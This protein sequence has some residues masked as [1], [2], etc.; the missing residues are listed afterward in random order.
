MLSGIIN[1]AESN[2]PEWL[3]ET[4]VPESSD[5]SEKRDLPVWKSQCKRYILW[6][7]G[8]GSWHVCVGDTI[9][10]GGP[11]LNHAESDISLLANISRRHATLQRHGEDWFIHANHPTVVSGRTVHEQTFLRTGDEIRLGDRVRLGFRIPSP[12]ATTAVV[13]FESDHRPAQSVNGIILMTDNCLLGPRR[14]YHIFCPDWP[15]LLVLFNRDDRLCC[16]SNIP[17]KLNQTPVRD[18]AELEHGSV[19]SGEE[20]RFRVECLDGQT[21]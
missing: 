1:P 11:A 18:V 7:D 16:R 9:A 4:C 14:D 17:M 19:V 6:I 21:T 20:F 12:L 5:D 15:E 8:V 13:D 3:R 2:C 10:I